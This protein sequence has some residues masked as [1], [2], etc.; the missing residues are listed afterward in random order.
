M[1]ISHE[2]RIERL[3][4]TL[5]GDLTPA[6]RVREVLKALAEEDTGLAL[7]IVELCPR[8]TYRMTDPAYSNCP[9]RIFH[10]TLK[11]AEMGGLRRKGNRETRS[12][13]RPARPHCIGKRLSELCG[14]SGDGRERS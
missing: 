12:T 6:D 3:E 7:R 11:A 13:R 5:L 14:Q 10:L 1:A 2:Y 4:S 9:Y 8:S